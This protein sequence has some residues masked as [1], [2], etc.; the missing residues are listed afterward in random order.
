MGPQNSTEEIL[1]RLAEHKFALDQSAIVVQ[2]DGHGTIEYVNDK[3]CE[4]SEY[5]R[6]ELLGKSHRL[7][8]SGYH[9]KEFF[10]IM[11]S[12]ISKGQIWRGEICN[13][14]KSGKHYWV[15]TTI[16][17]F[18]DASGK[19][20]QYLAI[21]QDITSLKEAEQKIL[22]QQAQMVASSKLSAIGEMASAITHEINN[23]LGVILGRCEMFKTLVGNGMTDIPKLL[24]LVD[25]IEING[26][27]ID[28]IVKSMKA[29]SHQGDED[30][31]LETPLESIF[32]DLWELFAERFK[33]HGVKLTINNFDK[34]LA[35]ICRSHEIL[36]VFVNLFNNSFDAI[37]NCSKKWVDV[38]V[39][40]TK[41]EVQISLTDSG[42]GIPPNVQSM[43]FKPF[44]S[45][46]KVQY[47]TGLG[48]SISRSLIQR[49]H[50]RLVYDSS[51]AN[52]KF[53]IWLSL[54]NQ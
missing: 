46:K 48:L 10:N 4:I 36:Q 32:Q 24:H 33:I 26:K 15:A 39:T 7:I 45:T 22:E 20:L 23:P 41:A 8:N 12:A 25:T 14:A 35:I 5:N 6:D 19:P 21:R 52:T 34:S 29:L 53:V 16:V 44:H 18:L 30:P 1:K 49:H 9:S 13:R 31:M 50:G 27:R 28:K 47:G 43:L 38:N 3:F 51:C 2:T 40:A 54:A 42:T 37:S 17:P 11:W